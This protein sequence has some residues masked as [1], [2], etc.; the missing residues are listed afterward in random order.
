MKTEDYIKDTLKE[1]GEFAKNL[2]DPKS[3][4][5]LKKFACFIRRYPKR[6]VSVETLTKYVA[7]EGCDALKILVE[8]GYITVSRSRATFAIPRVERFVS[9]CVEGGDEIK[10]LVERR[11]TSLSKL[12]LDEALEYRLRGSILGP[13]FH[14]ADLCGKGVIEK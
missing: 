14:I 13:D 6:S 8:N 11:S 10:R 12:S 2:N 9:M 3:A 4:K 5:V 1:S 7:T